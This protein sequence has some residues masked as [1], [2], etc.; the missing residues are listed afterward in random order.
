MQANVGG[1]DRAARIVV[2]LALV[3]FAFFSTSPYRWW[4]LIGFVL[5]LTGLI[6]WCPLYLPFG[7]KTCRDR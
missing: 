1:I 7:I 3:L 5:I 2:G 4:G 6:R